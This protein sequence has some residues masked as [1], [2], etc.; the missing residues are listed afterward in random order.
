[1][2]LQPPF[3][4]QS[5]CSAGT[6]LLSV[7][8]QTTLTTPLL[9]PNRAYEWSHVRSAYLVDVPEISVLMLRL[10]PLGNATEQSS[11][12]EVRD[13]HAEFRTILTLTELVS[14]INNSGH[15]TLHLPRK[16][17]TPTPLLDLLF[18]IATLLVRDHEV[19]ALGVSGHNIV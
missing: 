17:Y 6:P 11:P 14:A 16:A 8:L 5:S 9:L 10:I 12:P 4:N 15:P 18:A 19:V 7:Y 3:Y 13:L 2:T 1:M